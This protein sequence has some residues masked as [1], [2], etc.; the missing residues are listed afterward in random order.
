MLANTVDRL[1][2][3]DEPRAEKTGWKA[4]FGSV[5]FHLS[6]ED[7]GARAALEPAKPDGTQQLQAAARRAFEMG[8]ED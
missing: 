2:Q 4:L 5:E 1:T 7:V 8:G 6:R 3:A